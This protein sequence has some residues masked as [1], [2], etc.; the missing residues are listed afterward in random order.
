MGLELVVNKSNRKIDEES[1]N[2]SQV[3]KC[4]NRSFDT[5]CHSTKE[6]LKD[7]VREISLNVPTLSASS[8][9]LLHAMW[10]LRYASAL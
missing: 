4:W 8:D 9:S 10:K 5:W 6:E 7:R 2:K 3:S 1:R